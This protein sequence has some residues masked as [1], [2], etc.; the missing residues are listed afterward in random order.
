MI[1]WHGL[2]STRDMA[3]AA[4]ENLGHDPAKMKMFAKLVEYRARMALE[5]GISRED[6]VSVID[7]AARLV[8]Q[9]DR[10]P[11]LRN[12]VFLWRLDVLEILVPAA[13]EDAIERQEAVRDA[14]ARDDAAFE[15]KFGWSDPIQ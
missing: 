15:A 12:P 1:V 14:L 9:D 3:H 5:S 4:L 13:A 10:S 6:L 8:K 7:Y 2:M 11:E